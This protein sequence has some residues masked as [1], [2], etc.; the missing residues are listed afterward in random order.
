MNV[1]HGEQDIPAGEIVAYRLHRLTMS[2]RYSNSQ[3]E[4]IQ[5][6]ACILQ[7]LAEISL[8][9]FVCLSSLTPLTALV[10]H[11]FSQISFKYANGACSCSYPSEIRG[12]LKT[13]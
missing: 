13:C 10:L 7:E 6:E 2:L 11:T 3:L 12:F 4:K 5:S 8:P 1:K 9:V